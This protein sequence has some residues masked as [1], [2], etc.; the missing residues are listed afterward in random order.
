MF[1]IVRRETKFFIFT[2]SNG[3]ITIAEISVLKLS[4]ESTRCTEPFDF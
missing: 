2:H 3:L 1:K 4:A